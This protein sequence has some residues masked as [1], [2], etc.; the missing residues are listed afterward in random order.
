MEEERVKD[1]NP[2]LAE[3]GSEFDDPGHVEMASAL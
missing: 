1:I 3:Q 2:V